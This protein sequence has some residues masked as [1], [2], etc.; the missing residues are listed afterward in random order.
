MQGI[1]AIVVRGRRPG[2]VARAKQPVQ[3][4]A[5]FGQRITGQQLLQLVKPLLDVHRRQQPGQQQR[6][7]GQQHPQAI[8]L[9]SQQAGHPHPVD[10]PV[11][12]TRPQTGANDEQQRQKQAGYQVGIEVRV[13]LVGEGIG[14]Q[15]QADREHGAHDTV[16]AINVPDRVVGQKPDQQGQQQIQNQ[17]ILI[18]AAGQG[19]AAPGDDALQHLRDA[20]QEVAGPG[21]SHQQHHTAE[22]VHLTEQQGE[23]LAMVAARQPQAKQQPQ[24]Q[25]RDGCVHLQRPAGRLQRQQGSVQQEQQHGEGAGLDV[26]QQLAQG[27]ATLP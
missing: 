1:P 2:H 15:Y 13:A 12:F 4:I 16:H 17:G 21:G 9:A 7:Q 19:V 6:H 22:A 3:E 23:K 5:G 20:L 26:G 18:E 11:P 24:Q 14:H 10:G 27:Q 25:R 8:K